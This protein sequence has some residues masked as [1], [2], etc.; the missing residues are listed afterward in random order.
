MIRSIVATLLTTL[1]AGSALATEQ[2]TAVSYTD[3]SNVIERFRY[4][5]RVDVTAEKPMAEPSAQEQ[6]DAELEA[7]LEES[8]ALEDEG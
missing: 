8:A 6:L 5:E 1:M 4:L 7:I 3:Q 2:T